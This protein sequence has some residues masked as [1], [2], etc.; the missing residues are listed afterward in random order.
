MATPSIAVL[1]TH[2]AAAA[3]AR[4]FAVA[5]AA[6]VSVVLVVAARWRADAVVL[7][8]VRVG[9]RATVAASLRAAVCARRRQ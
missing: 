4:R 1:A 7:A 3:A 9:D 5:A 6:A 8:R 2:A